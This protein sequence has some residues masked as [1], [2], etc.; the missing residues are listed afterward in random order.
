NLAKD[1]NRDLR[2]RHSANA[3]TNR[4]ADARQRVVADAEF[5]QA[6]K[7]LGMSLPRAERTDIKAIALQR[8]GERRIVDLWI[9][10]QRDKCSVVVDV[11]RR[12]RRVRPLRDQGN[13]GKALGACK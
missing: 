13:V 2:R 8:I 6:L 9:M 5:L 1:R 3:K 7:A 11:E 4:R 12:Q 10:G